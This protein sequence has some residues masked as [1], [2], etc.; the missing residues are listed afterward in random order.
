M[1]LVCKEI[2]S[3]AYG[4]GMGRHTEAEVIEMGAKDLRALS[5]FLGIQVS[6]PYKLID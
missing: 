6:A 1:P 2:K 5:V 3:Q 4:Q